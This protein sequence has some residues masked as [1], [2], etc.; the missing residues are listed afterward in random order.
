M[1]AF[2]GTTA[3]EPMGQYRVRQPSP[4]TNRLRKK[5]WDHVIL[6]E[7][8]DLL[9]LFLVRYSRCFAALSMTDSFFC[10]LLRYLPTA[11][12]RNVQQFVLFARIQG[13]VIL[14]AQG[15]IDELKLHVIADAV[16]VLVA[17]IF[18]GNRPAR[19]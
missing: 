19:M 13:E 10:S 9:Y 14:A 8:K 17:P 6:S 2:A 5:P 1:L 3:L 4:K 11:E 7:A 12:R 16:D 18:K 15:R